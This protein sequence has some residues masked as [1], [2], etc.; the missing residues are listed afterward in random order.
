MPQ[1]LFDRSIHAVRELA[2]KWLSPSYL[3]SIPQDLAVLDSG[4]CFLPGKDELAYFWYRLAVQDG[5]RGP[6]GA[7]APV[8]APRLLY[9]GADATPQGPGRGNPG[10]EEGL[11]RR[12]A[13]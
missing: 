13:P 2:P 5:E 4:I 1:S 7:A 6:R 9:G 3:P 11:G 10:K 12:G 8:V